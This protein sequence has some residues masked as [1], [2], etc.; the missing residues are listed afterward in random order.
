MLAL[1]PLALSAVLFYV[2]Q[3]H[4]KTITIGGVRHEQVNNQVTAAAAD[5]DEGEVRLI[6]D[7]KNRGRV[8]AQVANMDGPLSDMDDHQYARQQK[9]REVEERKEYDIQHGGR[10]PPRDAID[11]IGYSSVGN[12]H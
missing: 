12:S 9:E 10:K 5:T 7:V 6:R 3:W 1:W 4:N 11:S 2:N 8:G